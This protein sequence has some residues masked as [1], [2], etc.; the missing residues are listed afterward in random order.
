MIVQHQPRYLKEEKPSAF[1]RKIPVLKIYPYHRQT[2][3]GERV[4][5]MTSAAKEKSSGPCLIYSS[6]PVPP[7]HGRRINRTNQSIRHHSPKPR[8]SSAAH[9]G[10]QRVIAGRR[11]TGSRGLLPV[12]GW[13]GPGPDCDQLVARGVGPGFGSARLV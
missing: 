6:S 8:A 12:L 9:A 1:G 7:V 13:P 4:H 11:L 5:K 2:G 3:T 10:I